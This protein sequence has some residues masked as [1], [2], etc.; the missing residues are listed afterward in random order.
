VASFLFTGSFT[1]FAKTID[2]GVRKAFEDPKKES[3][4]IERQKNEMLIRFP[5]EVLGNIGL[6]PM[7]KDVKN[8]VIGKIYEDLKKEVKSKKLSEKE[9]AIEKDKLGLYL[10]RS[11]MKKYDPDLYNK[12][13]GPGSPGYDAELEKK[14]LAEEKKDAREV[15][16]DSYYS[17]YGYDKPEESY[18]ERI[19][20]EDRER[21]KEIKESPDYDPNTNTSKEAMTRSELKTYFPDEYEKK[22]GKGSKYYEDKK[23]NPE[24]IETEKQDDER[25]SMLD[26]FYGKITSRGGA[27]TSRGGASTSRGGTSTSRGGTSTGRGGNSTSRGGNSTS[28][29]GM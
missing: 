23:K 2:L 5:I 24:N 11:D 18:S 10:T 21:L 12:T 15:V 13:F 6:I 1:P 14:K 4:A 27:S 9:K 7:Y 28:R 16:K 19:D 20:R 3:D 22:Y 8:I 29:G 25:K 17:L 26:S